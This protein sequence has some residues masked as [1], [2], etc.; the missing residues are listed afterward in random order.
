MSIVVVYIAAVSST[1][2]YSLA[3]SHQR[4]TLVVFAIFLKTEST[5]TVHPLTS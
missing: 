3:S 2:I 1:E 5:I 4:G